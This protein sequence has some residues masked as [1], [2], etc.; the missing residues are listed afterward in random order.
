MIDHYRMYIIRLAVVVANSNKGNKVTFT[1]SD[2]LLDVRMAPVGA[3]VH[4]G[5]LRKVLKRTKANTWLSIPQHLSRFKGSKAKPQKGMAMASVKFEAWTA[6]SH[7]TKSIV[8][9]V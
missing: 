2:G 1:I 4:W 3:Y 6:E 5:H 8:N 7:P 9:A